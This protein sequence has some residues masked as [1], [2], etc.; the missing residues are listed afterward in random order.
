MDGKGVKRGFLHSKYLFSLVPPPLYRKQHQDR[1]TY[2]RIIISSVYSEQ[3]VATEAQTSKS[4]YK[5]SRSIFKQTNKKSNAIP[6]L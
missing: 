5:I 6:R 3:K 1:P 2:R 4:A